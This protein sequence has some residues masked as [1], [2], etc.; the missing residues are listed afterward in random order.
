MVYQGALYSTESASTHLH[1]VG[2]GLSE[3]EVLE[4]EASTDGGEG[5]VQRVQ[6]FNTLTKP[7]G[8]RML[9]YATSVHVFLLV[10]CLIVVAS[11]HTTCTGGP[12][13]TLHFHIVCA[14]YSQLRMCDYI[15]VYHHGHRGLFPGFV[16]LERYINCERDGQ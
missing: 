5:L 10:C 9:S 8:V 12:M 7:D 15:I 14:S 4:D 11:W 3:G 2:P 16:C 1:K 6:N 13:V